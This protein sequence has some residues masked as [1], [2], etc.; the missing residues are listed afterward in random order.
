MKKLRKYGPFFVILLILIAVGVALLYFDPEAIITKVGVKNS[1][2]VLF[3]L[4]LIGGSSTFTSS[5]FYGSLVVF[6]AG[7]LNPVFMALAAA[8]GLFLSDVIYYFLGHEARV[9]LLERYDKY[10]IRI[11]KWLERHP[12]AAPIAIYVY[13]GF[14]P[15]PGDLLM[16]VLALV[17][18]PLRKVI[19][20][21]LLG[22]FTLIFLVSFLAQQGIAIVG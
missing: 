6:A 3:F 14:T 15:F 20:P 9:A 17:K 2:V 4:A 1:Y 11:S 19:L 18:Y 13:S 7:G 10:V 12:N 16:L 8:P 21:V 5:S 22:A